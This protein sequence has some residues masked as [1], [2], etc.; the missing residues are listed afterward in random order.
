MT[1]T[2]KNSQVKTEVTS[3]AD[4]EIKT[5]KTIKMPD[6]RELVARASASLISSLR[7]IRAVLSSEKGSTYYVS[8][9]GMIRGITAGLKLPE[10]DMLMD[11][12]NY[13]EKVLFA[14]I[15][16][17]IADRFVITQFH[18][19]QERKRIMKLRDLQQAQK[20]VIVNMEKEGKS[21]EEVS[22]MKAKH[23]KSMVDLDSILRGEEVELEEVPVNN[24][25][26][27]EQTNV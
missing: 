10:Q 4:Q 22:E 9:R 1:E 5:G 19:N 25:Q 23:Q 3:L 27:G 24:K 16:Q 8:R 15:Q 14:K 26:E 12:Q 6:E 17:L 21:E 2:D 20:D 7:E 18:V 11:L 13:G